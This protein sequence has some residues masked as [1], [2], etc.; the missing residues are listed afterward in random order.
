MGE[1]LI[2]IN[3]PSVHTHQ[4]SHILYKTHYHCL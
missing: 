3:L 2:E 4:T 1:E